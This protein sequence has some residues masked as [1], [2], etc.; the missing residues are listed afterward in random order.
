MSRRDLE[1]PPGGKGK[2]YFCGTKGISRM[3]ICFKNE[4]WNEKNFSNSICNCGYSSHSAFSDIWGKKRFSIL[5]Y[6]AYTC[7]CRESII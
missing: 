7:N 5:H 4:V 1:F 2:K 3:Y 6:N